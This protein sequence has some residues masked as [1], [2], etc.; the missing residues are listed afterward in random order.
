MRLPDKP[1]DWKKTLKEEGDEVFK[2]I[3]EKNLFETVI[4]YNKR[5]LYWD[6]LKYRTSNKLEQ[7]YLWTLMKFIR[8]EK[9]EDISFKHIDLKITNLSEINKYLHRIDKYLAGNIEIHNKT[10]GLEKKYIISSLME[11]AIASSMIEGAM[12]TRKV[13]KE[14]LKQRRKPK[15]KSEQMVVNGYETM[16]EMV[17]RKGEKLTPQFLLE[18]Q[19]MI[20]KETL[21]NRDDVGKFRDSNDIIVG[22]DSN[23]LIYH[24]PPDYKKINTLIEEFCKFANTN[25]EDFIHPVIKGIILHFLIGFIHPFNDGNGRTARSIFYWYVLSK[26]YWLFEYMSVSRRILRSKKKYGE[27]YLYT[28]LDEMDITYFVKYNLLAVNDSLTDLIEYIQVK[29]AQQN[30]VH[31]FVEKIKTINYRQATILKDM[32]KN[33]DKKYTIQEISETYNI[34][35]QTARTDLIK[36]AT[37]DYAHM[38][39]IGKMFVFTYNSDNKK[40]S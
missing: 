21:E 35:Y 19:A 31:K 7:K 24:T 17:K 1:I 38:N 30:E 10:L 20:T 16:Q 13:A 3:Q 5:Y 23:D 4:E 32:M 22:N 33:P 11:E 25:E 39:K 40:N 15:D 37:L 28:E 2:F 14:M 36:L 18:I 6:E 9:Y 8:S 27:A 12:T 29:Q 26:G 34:V